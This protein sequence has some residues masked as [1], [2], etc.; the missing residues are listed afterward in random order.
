MPSKELQFEKVIAYFI[1]LSVIDGCFGENNKE[2]QLSRTKL[3][4]CFVPQSQTSLFEKF[5]KEELPVGTRGWLNR[6]SVRLL[7]SAQ[8]RISLFVNL[9]PA[10]GSV[11]FARVLSPNK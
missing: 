3:L 6:V 1:P 11:L 9:S 2:K 7:I 10:S 8:V 4:L 5:T